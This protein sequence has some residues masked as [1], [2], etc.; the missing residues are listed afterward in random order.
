MIETLIIQ[1]QIA[2][3]KEKS[4]SELNKVFE[5]VRLAVDNTKKDG[6]SKKEINAIKQNAIKTFQNSKIYKKSIKNT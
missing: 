3:L 2:I 6:L 1:Q 5:M 4:P